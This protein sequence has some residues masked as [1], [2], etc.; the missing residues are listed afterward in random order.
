MSLIP[1]GTGMS[2]MLTS[3]ALLYLA[4]ARQRSAVVLGAWL[5]VLLILIP[6]ML[7]Y[8]TGWYQFGY[9]FSLDFMVPVMVLLA[10][11]SREKMPVPMQALIVLSVAINAWG[12]SWCCG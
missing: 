10:Y 9:R 2:L 3:P 7:Y 1:D 11:A 8:N 6:L 12:L 5:S 4:K